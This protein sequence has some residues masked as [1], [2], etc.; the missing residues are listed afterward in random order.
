MATY[1]IELNRLLTS[2]ILTESDLFASLNIDATE[3]EKDEIKSL[4]INHFYFR[5]IGQETPDRFLHYFNLAL[6]TH[7]PEYNR[8]YKSF[9]SSLDPFLNEQ[10]STKTAAEQT[11][12]KNGETTHAI[13]TEEKA[14]QTP[15]TQVLNPDNNYM[16]NYGA[17][18]ETDKITLKDNTNQNATSTTE[19][20]G[21]TGKTFAAV[22][23]EYRE[24][25]ITINNLWLE[26]LDGCFMQVY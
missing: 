8:L 16:S 23:K 4:I 11:G 26:W 12:T 9:S 17:R 15:F 3:A 2:G 1:T 24:N 10:Y 5:E 6:Q 20:K 7:S 22:F 14:K 21:L 25:I 18:S 13:S 19:H